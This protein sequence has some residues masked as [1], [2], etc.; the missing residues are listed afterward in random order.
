MHNQPIPAATTH[1]NIL[2]AFRQAAYHCLGKARDA[3]FELT[4]AVLLTPAAPSLAHLSLCPLFR[5]RWPSVYEAL[6]DGRPDREALMR[7][8]VAQMPAGQR[9][10]LAGDHTAWPRPY[11]RT[12]RDRT[13]EHQPTPV[14]GNRPLTLG[15]GYSTLAWVPDPQG[16]WALPLRH[17]RIASSETPLGKASEQLRRACALLPRR[18]IA[19]FD[20]EYGCAPFVLATADIACDRVLRLRPNLCLRRAPPPYGGHGRP[21]RHG[22][23]FKLSDPGTW[24]PPAE[25]LE[26]E[27]AQLG[28]VQVQRWNALHF[29]KAYAQA[30][31]VVRIERRQARGTRRDPKDLWLAWVGAPP[32][33]LAQ[34]WRLYLRRF[35]VDHWYRFAKGRGHWT[36]PQV[37]TP[38]QSERWSDLM[39]LISWELY[40]AREVVSDCGLPWQKPQAAPAP[41]RVCQGMGS[42]LAVIGTPAQAPKVRGKSPGWRKGRVRQRRGCHAVVKKSGKKPIPPAQTPT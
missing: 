27:D 5:R 38:E 31:T 25:R 4:D 12:L 29:L 36:L 40:L 20:A 34:W 28:A 8:Y 42:I 2:K 10:L 21:R 11:A 35:A 13:V 26:V 23:K 32:P 39:P 30:M 7:L 17:E 3:L 1:L 41:G 19:L 6:Q 22:D 37:A 16:S 24:G 33:P 9:P 18:P 14:P 15:Q